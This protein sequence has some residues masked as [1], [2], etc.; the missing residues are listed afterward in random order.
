MEQSQ[1]KFS[2]KPIV[3][4]GSA[5]IDMSIR[6]AR[7]PKRGETILGGELTCALG[8]KGANQAM[9]A[10]R[11]GARVIFIARLGADNNGDLAMSALKKDK[12]DTSHIVRDRSL[13]TGV[14]CILVDKDGENSIAVAPGSNGKLSP[15][16]VSKA[17][18]IINEAGVLLM[19]LETP[20]NTICKTAE[21]AREA[22]LISILNP[23]PARKLPCELLHNISILT[24]NES[25]AEILTGIKI[26]SESTAVQAADVLLAMG[27]KALVITLG[28][29]GALLAQGSERHLIPGFKVKALDSTA[30]GDVF[31]GALATFLTEGKSLSQS[32]RFA[33]AAAALCVTRLGAEPAIPWRQ[34]IEDFLKAGI[35]Y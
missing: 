29:Q 3:V 25:E 35:L 19:Q 12:I 26:K 15:S 32:V 9:A 21:L 16:N 31:N 14:A 33:N 2:T 11:A 8:G 28:A 5:N 7:I 13:P 10:A 22:G 18:K 34:E 20:L 17:H 1:I 30:A 4:V 24:P 27:V 23:A 6:V